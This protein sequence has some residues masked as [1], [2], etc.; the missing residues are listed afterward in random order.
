[1]LHPVSLTIHSILNNEDPYLIR[2][3]QPTGQTESV[4]H[5]LSRRDAVILRTRALVIS[6]VFVE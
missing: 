2:I 4:R 3:D 6:Q 1:M 5:E